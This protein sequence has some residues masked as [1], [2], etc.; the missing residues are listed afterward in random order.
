MTEV[1]MSTKEESHPRNPINNE[2]GNLRDGE[3]W[4]NL[5]K[6]QNN[7]PSELQR[8]VKELRSKLKRV[9]EDNERILKA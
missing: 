8:D 2:E 9:R 1:G 4:T 7:N 6:S 3:I 5:N